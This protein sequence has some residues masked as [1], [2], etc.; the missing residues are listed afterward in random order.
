MTSLL[1]PLE[2]EARNTKYR[3]SDAPLPHPVL[4]GQTEFHYPIR[5]TSFPSQPPPQTNQH[6]PTD[7]S[8]PT[9]QRPP[10]FRVR[11]PYR[12]ALRT[13]R[14]SLGLRVGRVRYTERLMENMLKCPPLVCPSSI[15]RRLSKSC[16][17]GERT[18]NLEC[19]LIDKRMTVLP[20]MLS[21]HTHL[22]IRLLIRISPGP[23]VAQTDT[24]SRDAQED[25]K[26]II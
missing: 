19:L 8:S 7:F 6:R 18:V 13:A 20:G 17:R 15:F 24:R 9:F 2:I 23:L 3:K 4:S 14:R 11:F 25:A 5:F 1:T 26:P 21:S 10:K 16:G 22:R 12:H